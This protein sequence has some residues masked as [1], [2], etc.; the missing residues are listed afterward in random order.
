LVADECSLKPTIIAY[1]SSHGPRTSP[2][3]PV[4][5]WRRSSSDMNKLTA[6][7]NSPYHRCEM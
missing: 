5:E 2:L 1:A 3:L 6:L 4:P 7:L